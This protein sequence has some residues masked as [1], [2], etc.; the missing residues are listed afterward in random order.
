MNEADFRLD[1]AIEPKEIRSLGYLIKLISVYPHPNIYNPIELKD[2]IIT[3]IVT[4]GL[5]S[6]PR[7]GFRLYLSIS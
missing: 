6:F 1:S 2:Y 5:D 4:D 7:S 3:L